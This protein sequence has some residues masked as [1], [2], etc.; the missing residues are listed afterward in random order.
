M[1]FTYNAHGKPSLT[2]N[3]EQIEFNL[4]HSGHYILIGITKNR[5]VGVDI[6]RV[7]LSRNIRHI[8]EFYYHPEE[9]GQA[10]Y[11]E[12]RVR[13]TPRVTVNISFF[14]VELNAASRWL[15][16]SVKY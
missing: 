9:G 14:E 10:V 12:M 15:S 3:P 6:E 7:N 5:R 4:S 16:S 2:E 8:G 13:N 1:T 11:L